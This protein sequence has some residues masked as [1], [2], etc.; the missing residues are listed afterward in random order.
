MKN[1]LYKNATNLYKF[2]KGIAELQQK[3]NLNE[4]KF[5]IKS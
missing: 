4:N 5:F 2:M 3:H 1:N